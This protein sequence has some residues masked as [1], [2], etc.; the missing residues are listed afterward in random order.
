MGLPVAAPPTDDREREAG[1]EIRVAR[2][3][4]RAAAG[5]L[6]AWRLHALLIDDNRHGG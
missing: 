1:E 6:G 4:P 2:K 3:N 5:V